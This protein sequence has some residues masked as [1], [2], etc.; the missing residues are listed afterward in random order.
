MCDEILVFESVYAQK[1]KG[2]I[3]FDFSW[4]FKNYSLSSR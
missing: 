2:S 3:L 1:E 4:S